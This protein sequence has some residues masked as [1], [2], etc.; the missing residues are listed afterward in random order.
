MAKDC[1]DKAAIVGQLL[2]IL[3]VGIL[4]GVIGQYIKT[5]ADNISTSIKKGELVQSLISDLAAEDAKNI[6]QDVA[7]IALN[8]SLGDQENDLIVD[9]AQQIV[10]QGEYEKV[11][12]TV[13]YRI[14]E[15]R[16]PAL[17]KDIREKALVVAA[18]A[19]LRS[20]LRSNVDPMAFIASPSPTPQTAIAERQLIAKVLPNLVLIQFKNEQSR[21]IFEALRK[22]LNDAGLNAPGVDRL[23]EQFTSAIRFFSEEDRPLAE[24]VAEITRKFFAG[25]SIQINPEIKNL[26]KTGFKGQPGQIEI[27]IDL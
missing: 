8:H 11:V 2:N 9:I 22:D 5:G 7:L 18:S 6:R 16:S 24:Q 19:G 14:L 4:M 1:W 3:V 20:E 27:W 23:D 17:A 10:R 13:A 26:S 25:R 21:T 15:Q 12:G